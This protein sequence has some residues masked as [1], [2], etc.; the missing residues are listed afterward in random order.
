[1]KSADWQ[2]TPFTIPLLLIG[3]LCLWVAYVAWRRRSVPEAVPFAILM[4]GIAGWTL[5][6]LVEKSLVPHELRRLVST[7][8]YVF[9]VLTPGAWFAFAVRFARRDRWFPRRAGGL[10]FVEPVLALGL[11]FTDHY[12]GL[13]RAATAMRLAGPYA[14]LVVRYGPLFWIHAVYS[15][16]LFA[17]GGVFV[18]M[19]AVN[20]PDW[21][22]VRLVVV[23]GAMLAPT[24]G[25]IAYIFRLQSE[26]ATDLT[27]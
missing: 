12:H 5:L 9:I 14:V 1:M 21:S 24:L 25:N 15:Y 16:V 17:A 23:L 2:N 3:L 11:A 10:L 8:V 22:P 20:R 19:G 27:P 7:L 4:T 26:R 6:S 18:V 13:F